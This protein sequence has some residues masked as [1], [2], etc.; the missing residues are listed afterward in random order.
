MFLDEVLSNAVREAP[1][2]PALYFGDDAWTFAALERWVD[3]LAAGL[4]EFAAPGDRVAVLAENHPAVV[5]AYYAVP[6]AGM[7][8]VL[9]N[10]RLAA[11]ELAAMLRDSGARVLIGERELLD[12]V[13]SSTAD[14]PGPS[15]PFPTRTPF[16]SGSRRVP[17]T[18]SRSLAREPDRNEAC[19]IVCGRIDL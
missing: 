5:A 19:P 18:N 15:P 3:A 1:D 2:E 7:S 14:C 16:W 13:Q 4:S 17:R 10:Y 6:R 11:P 8:L 12:R 9:L